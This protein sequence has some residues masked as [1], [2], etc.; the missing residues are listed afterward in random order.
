MQHV[1][2]L[3][4]AMQKCKGKKIEENNLFDY[5]RHDIK[6][7]PH[8]HSIEKDIFFSNHCFVRSTENS[9]PSRNAETNSNI[10]TDQQA[11]QDNT[12]TLSLNENVIFSYSE[13]FTAE[14]E[15]AVFK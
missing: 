14:D 3:Y 1:K 7:I 8:K 4:S 12:G 15:K 5:E 13:N 11:Y 10:L 6:S 9:I 2:L